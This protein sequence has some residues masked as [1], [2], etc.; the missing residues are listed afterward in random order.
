MQ[1]Q[2]IQ[3]D[4]ELYSNQSSGVRK[5]KTIKMNKPKRILLYTLLTGI[6]LSLLVTVV[7][8][9]N[10][11]FDNSIYASQPTYTIKTPAYSS[12]NSV[13]SAFQPTFMISIKNRNND[14]LIISTDAVELSKVFEEQN[15]TLDDSCVVNYPLNTIVYD[16]MEVV[17]DSIT[18]ENVDVLSSI[19]YESKTVELQTIPKGTKKVVTKGQE[20]TLTSTYRKKFVN[21]VFDS[22]EIV[23]QV[24]T[25]EP[26]TQVI[27]VGV[28]GKL[29]GKDGKTYNYSYYLDVSATCYGKADGSGSI[30]AT[31]T[32]AREGVIAVDPRV[33]KLGSK[34]Y[35]KG[36]Y[37][38]IGVC[39]AED[40]G[41]AIK[42]N[43]IDVYMEGTLQ[44]LLQF[45]R[46]NMRV[47]ILE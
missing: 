26:V 29:V 15:I 6:V 16:G 18:Y 20:G 30:T 12:Y 21:G 37:K 25:K 7:V 17:I 5:L 40:T 11:S 28:G 45:G 38:D 8:A 2:K 44:Q 10:I 13:F 43:K 27:Q 22:E 1:V 23:N 14:K 42:G 46:R 3:K 24:T 32:V 39:Y 36:D 47:Y 19:P 4:Y 33:I 31:G 41:G 9:A 35:V 34:V